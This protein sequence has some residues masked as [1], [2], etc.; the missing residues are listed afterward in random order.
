MVGN[1]A[2]QWQFSSNLQLPLTD[3][4]NLILYILFDFLCIKTGMM[5]GETGMHGNRGYFLCITMVI[6]G[7]CYLEIGLLSALMVII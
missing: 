2:S 3:Q 7:K 5:L 4:H 6:A 1:I